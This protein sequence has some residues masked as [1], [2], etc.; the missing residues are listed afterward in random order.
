MQMVPTYDVLT[1]NFQFYYGVKA[2]PIDRI[3]TSNFG[4]WYFLGL[5]ISNVILFH[6]A[7]RWWCQAAAPGETG[8]HHG[9]QVI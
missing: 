3:H 9:K 5:L 4:F 7:G 2:I 6:G 8:N 1:Y